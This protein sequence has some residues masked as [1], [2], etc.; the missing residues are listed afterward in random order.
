MSYY[1]HR[2]HAMLAVAINSEDAPSLAKLKVRGVLNWRSTGNWINI[3]QHPTDF[4][5]C[6]FLVKE[7]LLIDLVFI[8]PT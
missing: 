5:P 6:R 8:N 2:R 3:S 7:I 1:E 4:L